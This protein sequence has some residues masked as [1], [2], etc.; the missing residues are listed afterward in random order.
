M[1]NRC[2]ESEF[3][4]LVERAVRIGALF[5]DIEDIDLGDPAALAELRMILDE[6]DKALAL[7]KAF[8]A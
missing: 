2:T 4:R 7:V 8:R 3:M 5:P 6:F 1:P